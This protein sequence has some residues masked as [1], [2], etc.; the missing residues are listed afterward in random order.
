MAE[1][2]LPEPGGNSEETSSYGG[3]SF[4]TTAA[5]PRN[6][7]ATPDS[8]PAADH[9]SKTSDRQ[10]APDTRLGNGKGEQQELLIESINVSSATA[11]RLALLES[12]AHIQFIQ[13]TCLAKGL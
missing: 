1:P 3:D 10:E 12:D 6:H 8:R 5:A 2:A 4:V 7:E 11:N 13:E 9:T